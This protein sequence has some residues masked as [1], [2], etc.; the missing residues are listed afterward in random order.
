VCG[1]KYRAGFLTDSDNSKRRQACASHE[2]KKVSKNI[3][4]ASSLVQLGKSFGAEHLPT[5]SSR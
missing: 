5:T 3:G 4:Q 1:N 2:L